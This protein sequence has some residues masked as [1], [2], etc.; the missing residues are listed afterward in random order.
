M[1]WLAGL[2]FLA[3][4]KLAQRLQHKR[5]WFL[6]F[7]FLVLA[8]ASLAY[9]PLPFGWGSIA[10]LVASLAGWVLGWIGSL[11]GVPAAIIAGL[12][13]VVTIAFGLVDLIKDHRPDGAAK[14]MVYAVPVLVLLA[15]GPLAPT[16]YGFIDTL[17]GFGPQVVANIA[18]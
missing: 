1:L 11:I 5:L 13:L 12:L 16:I 3:F 15:A 8:V 4:R 6:P 9:A 14:T 2:L 18:S 10:G 7:V 17:G